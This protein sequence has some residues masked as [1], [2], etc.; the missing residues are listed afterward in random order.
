[1]TPKSTYW[2]RWRQVNIPISG[3]SATWDTALR[4]AITRAAN[5][6][7]TTVWTYVSTLSTE[8]EELIKFRQ[9]RT[10]KVASSDS[11][12]TDLNEKLEALETFDAPHPLSVDLAVQMAK[13]YVVED[14]YR[15]QLYDL[16]MSEA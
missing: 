1:M 16:V 4:N 7:F 8:A 12:F 15:A 2:G 14:R 10:I 6:R 13:K 9:A 5:R 11:F 3:W